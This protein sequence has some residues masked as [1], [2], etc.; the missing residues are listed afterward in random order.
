MKKLIL[1]LMLV[2]LIP[3]SSFANQA[4]DIKAGQPAPVDGVLFDKEKANEIKNELIE[5][6]G[7]VRTNNS[8]NKTIELQTKNNELT[9]QTN[10][11]LM[12]RNLELTKS[13]ND[14]RETST[15]TKVLYFVGGVV[16]TGAAVWGATRLNR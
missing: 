12:G 1:M 7:L 16:I 10:E 11:I 6:D 13:L 2:S 15:F 14:S 3:V 8:L 5:K 4:Y 9:N